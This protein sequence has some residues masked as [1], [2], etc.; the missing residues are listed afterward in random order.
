MFMRKN[1]DFSPTGKLCFDG[2]AFQSIEH[3]FQALL[4]TVEKLPGIAS[5]VGGDVATYPVIV[6]SIRNAKA[7]RDHRG[8][9]TK[10]YCWAVQRAGGQD[11]VV[12]LLVRRVQIELR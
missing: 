5:R 1:G 12:Y 4:D 7:I 8:E 9:A 10:A 2:F 3:V 6:N 11:V